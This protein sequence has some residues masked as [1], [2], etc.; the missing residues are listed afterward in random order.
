MK[1]PAP[2]SPASPPLQQRSKE[3]KKG[4]VPLSPPFQAIPSL[5]PHRLSLI[6][7]L[8]HSSLPSPFTISFTRSSIFLQ[9]CPK[10]TVLTKMRCPVSLYL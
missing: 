9:G 6:A 2:V 1:A 3:A 7:N 8:H 4:A 10:F 5:V